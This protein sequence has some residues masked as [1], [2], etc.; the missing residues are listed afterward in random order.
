VDTRSKGEFFA[1]SNFIERKAGLGGASAENGSAGQSLI[2][3][4]EKL[5]LVDSRATDKKG[6]GGGERQGA[7]KAR[8]VVRGSAVTEAENWEVAIDKRLPSPMRENQ[9]RGGRI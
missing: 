6:L 4:G 1:T 8:W 5:F 7:R 3:G 9:G 2:T